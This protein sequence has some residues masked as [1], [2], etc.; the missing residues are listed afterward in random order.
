MFSKTIVHVLVPAALVISVASLPARAS[1]IN[2]DTPCPTASLGEYVGGFG[3]VNGCVLGNLTLYNF[4]S[5]QDVGGMLDTSAL[6]NIMVTADPASETLSFTGFAPNTTSVTQWFTIDFTI[7]PA[8]VI[9]GQTL[10]IDPTGVTVSQ[11][12]CGNGLFNSGL[13]VQYNA[14]DTS[15]QPN[16]GGVFEGSLTVNAGDPPKTI[17]F[18][19]GPL[20]E[21]DIQT[22]LR[23][24][25]GGQLNGINSQV[26]ETVPEP[27][28]LGMSG[29]VLLAAFL[30]RRG[31]LKGS[32]D[33]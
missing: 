6:N 1:G 22:V 16:C 33:A 8:P 20:S 17:T 23:I 28:T 13:Y 25:P 24:D 12:Y 4:Y 15:N 11:Y 7:D 30:I 18:A 31:L 26:I 14:G 29:C 2:S 9:G 5:A 3:G 10:S 27:A 21:L 32:G 19:F